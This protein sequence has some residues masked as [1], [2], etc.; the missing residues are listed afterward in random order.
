[1]NAIRTIK[2]LQFPPI[3]ILS[4]KRFIFDK[5]TSSSTKINK[6]IEYSK[7]LNLS[8]YLH[9]DASDEV[10]S[11]SQYVLHSVVAHVGT[12]DYGHY[13]TYVNGDCCE[14]LLTSTNIESNWFEFNDS[15]V[16]QMWM[17]MKLLLTISETIL[18]IKQ[19]IF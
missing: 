19:H 13:I 14:N 7:N 12:L 3:L 17:K 6:C 9:V 10:K 1:M 11:N 2:Y 16:Q 5:K 18:K 15:K 8:E 4:L